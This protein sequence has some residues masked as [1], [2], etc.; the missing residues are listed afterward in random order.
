MLT[1]G[2]DNNI[3]MKSEINTY[4]CSSC[5]LKGGFFSLLLSVV[6]LANSIVSKSPLP[7]G[8][9]GIGWGGKLADCTILEP[10]PTPQPL[11]APEGTP[12]NGWGAYFKNKTGQ[13]WLL[14]ILFFMSLMPARAVSHDSVLEAG[15]VAV[16]D[17]MLSDAISKGLVSGASVVIGD[18]EGVLYRHSTGTVGFSSRSGK[19]KAS[20]VF[21]VASLTKVFATTPAIVK[22]MDEGKLS[23]LD[24]VSRWYPQFA[25]SEIT[26]LNLLTHTS[27]LKDF[28]IA[29]SNPMGS[30]IEKGAAQA[31]RV[32]PGSSFLYADINFIILGDIVRRIS[33]KTLDRFTKDE[34]Y[35]PL[36]MK[37]S[38]FIPPPSLE[39]A[40]TLGR[41]RIA[42]SG[43]VQDEN[44]R[45]MGGVAG[46]AGLFSTVT[47]L[48]R[49]SSM[50]LN[51][52]QLN[53]TR[54]LSARSVAQMTAPY[55]FSNGKIV[56]GLGWDRESRYSAPKGALFSEF[57]FGHT[58]YSGTSIWVDPE[59][60]LYVILL[61]TR[62]DYKNKKKFN[63]LRSDISTLAAAL[64]S[65]R[66]RRN[67]VEIL[68]NADP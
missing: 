43:I 64:F 59:V 48:A 68:K 4:N 37:S 18:H 62:L 6:R 46:H 51:G 60:D 56:R 66:E 57:S 67:S 65:G 16:I 47:D 2:P 17:L 9:G 30:A 32:K 8:G 45:R 5:R 19:I 22:L 28:A 42:Q 24:P 33:G 54:V 39:N 58:G 55:Y 20:T 31:G 23:L 50:L 13:F 38:G 15:R 34:F 36:G 27:G 44:A 49:F 7:P 1:T 25:G 35:K 63:R 11:Y 14:L 3:V 12:V 52:G 40:H 10:S 21:D 53:G 26:I 29:S 61:T 41:H